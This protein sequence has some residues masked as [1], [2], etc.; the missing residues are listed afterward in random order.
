MKITLTGEKKKSSPQRILYI[1]V[2][3]LGIAVA[4]FI[5]L[6]YYLNKIAGDNNTVAPVQNDQT[7]A[8]NQGTP[9]SP[10]AEAPGPS[11]P[12][13]PQANSPLEKGREYKSSAIRATFRT[14]DKPHTQNTDKKEPEEDANPPKAPPDGVMY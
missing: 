11:A 10:S 5:I 7:T 6:S 4:C 3:M 13:S 9:E 12:E 8:N 14:V 1:T 2:L